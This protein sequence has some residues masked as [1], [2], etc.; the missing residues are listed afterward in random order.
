VCQL[1]NGVVLVDGASGYVGSHLTNQLQRHGYSARCLVRPQ[2]SEVDVS[3]LQSSG[4][5]VCKA[6]LMSQHK[7]V[8]RLFEGVEVAVHLIGSVAP[9]RGESLDDLHVEMTR[10]FAQLCKATAV[11]KIVMVTSLGAEA[12][13]QSLYHRTKWLAEQALKDCGVPCIIL[14]PAL[15]VG[16]TFGVRNSK[17]IA[18][19]LELIRTRRSVPIIGGGANK[20]QPVFIDDVVAAI[21]KCVAE[22]GGASGTAAPVLEIAGPEVITMRQLYERLMTITQINKP[23]MDIPLPVA[24][25][26]AFAAQYL[27]AV[28]VLSLDQIKLSKSDNIS[29]RD[30]LLDKLSIGATGLSEALRSY[31]AATGNLACA[32]VA[33]EQERV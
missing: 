10:R 16:K 25:V 4:A 20:I 27:Q 9:K 5:Q 28:P 30:D 2:A 26:V 29:S 18:R 14:R 33:Q 11:G 22:I 17:L 21:I 8:E 3:T 19:I 31:G 24:S 1:H 32:P 6:D 13:A 12:S 15:I 23:L 7:D